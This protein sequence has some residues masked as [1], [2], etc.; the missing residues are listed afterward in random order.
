MTF[1][2][3]Y[4][5]IY[6]DRYSVDKKKEAEF[7]LTEIFKNEVA[8]E[9]GKIT[10]DDM[11]DCDNIENLLKYEFFLLVEKVIEEPEDINIVLEAEEYIK[12]NYTNENLTIGD[13]CERC[14]TTRNILDRQ[15]TASFGKSVTEYIKCIRVEDA[16]ERLIAGGKVEEITA[17]CGFGSIKTMQRAFKSIFGKTPREYKTGF[18][19]SK[20][21][22]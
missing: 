7:I 1:N 3:N 21:V 16:A 12:T 2:V 20:I 13:I 22:K 18:L 6:F 8:I 19:D 17:L 15:F 14:N 9:N 11:C 10:V 4:E 5:H